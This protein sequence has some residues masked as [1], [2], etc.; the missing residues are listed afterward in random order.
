M[1]I[2]FPSNTQTRNETFSLFCYIQKESGVSILHLFVALG[3]R[4]PLLINKQDNTHAYAWTFTSGEFLI[5]KIE[6]P[7]FNATKN[8]QANAFFQYVIFAFDGL[9][10]PTLDKDDTKKRNKNEKS[11][12]SLAYFNKSPQRTNTCNS[13]SPRNSYRAWDARGRSD[14]LCR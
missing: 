12:D 8:K 10:K 4:K 1:N 3:R 11:K 13:T 14:S 9:I 7:T 6:F 5:N 2:R